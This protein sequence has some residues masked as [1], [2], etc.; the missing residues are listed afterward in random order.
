MLRRVLLATAAL[1]LFAGA[2]AVFASP[3]TASPAA[4]SERN[5]RRLAVRERI[6]SVDPLNSGGPGSASYAI[7]INVFEPLYQYHHLRRP[8]TIIP[9][10]A[11]A[12]PEATNDPLTWI[13]RIRDDVRFHDDACFAD[14]R[15]RYLV[16]ADIARTYCRIADPRSPATAWS[17]LAGHIVGLDAYRSGL[18]DGQDGSSSAVEGLRVIDDR[19]LQI[20]LTA[21]WPQMAM[22][23]AHPGTAIVPMEAVERYGFR[24]GTHAIGTGPYRLAVLEPNVRVELRRWDGW[25]SEPY[26]DDGGPG[27]AEAGLLVDAGKRMP[28]I[29]SLEF[30]CVQADQPSW[31]MFMQ[32]CF[33][34][35][36]IPSAHWSDV[37]G[38][39]RGILPEQARRGMALEIF[40]TIFSRWIGFD[41]ADPLIGGNLPLRRAISLAIDREGFNRIFLSSRSVLPTGI[42]PR[43]LPEHRDGLD[44]PWMR[45]DPVEARRQ[46]AEAERLNGGPLPELTMRFGGQG[47]IQRQ[48]GDLIRRWFADVGLRIRIDHVEEGSLR[49]GLRDRSAQLAWGLGYS[50]RIPDP[51]DVMKAFRSGEAGSNPF[52]YSNPDFD[53]LYDELLTMPAGTERTQVCRRMEDMLLHDLPC[54]V[55]LD[56]TWVSVKHGWLLNRKPHAFYGL[57]GQAKYE[58][59]DTAARA[60]WSGAR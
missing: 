20:R 31:L 36:G 23:M 50:M 41:M 11:A 45:F 43:L 47:T 56:Y 44:N 48:I 10:L 12:L 16:A 24:F 3:W 37:V 18:A 38:P 57:G 26:P 52:R 7:G 32:G 15:G 4:A 30:T 27:D 19:T 46:V 6:A 40:P 54:V 51:V 22:V 39:D 55:M 58:R 8:Y 2:A 14:G 35:V 13:I 49:P 29:D 5:V 42:I 34:S 60:R 17:M 59:I 53:T 28:F 33:D 9:C 25:R 21:P 1:C